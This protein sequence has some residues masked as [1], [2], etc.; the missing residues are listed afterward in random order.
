MRTGSLC[1]P[2]SLATA[3]ASRPW[4]RS[5]S[6]PPQEWSCTLA[7]RP[8]PPKPTLQNAPSVLMNRDVELQGSLGRT[9][10]CGESWQRKLRSKRAPHTSSAATL[11]A[12]KSVLHRRSA[13][14]EDMT[15]PGSP[16]ARTRVC[17]WH[18]WKRAGPVYMQLA[19]RPRLEAIIHL[20]MSSSSCSP[21]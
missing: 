3:W 9:S 13:L 2:T 8:S 14:L 1:Q 4:Y 21:K 19:C 12:W 7:V 16:C 6:C 18:S 15:Q 10:T 17:T 20:L 5:N 11:E